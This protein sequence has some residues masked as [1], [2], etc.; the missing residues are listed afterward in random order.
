MATRRTLTTIKI[1]PTTSM[2]EALRPHRWNGAVT[3]ILG[4]AAL[5]SVVISLFS[6]S[7]SYQANQ[8]NARQGDLFEKQVALVDEATTA[9]QELARSAK[10]H[11]N[12]YVE[13]LRLLREEK[14]TRQRSDFRIALSEAEKLCGDCFT[15]PPDYQIR[16]HLEEAA[17]LEEGIG[18]H[19]TPIDYVKLAS[20]GSAVWD[21]S[22]IEQYAQRALKKSKKDPLHEHYAHLMLGHAHFA[23]FRIDKNADERVARVHFDEAVALLTKAPAS[24]SKERLLGEAYALWVAHEA[25]LKNDERVVKLKALAITHWSGSSSRECLEGQLSRDIEAATKGQRPLAPCRLLRRGNP[26][27][28]PPARAKPATSGEAAPKA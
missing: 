2:K 17:R 1:E 20:V 14:T 15:C 10:E 4:L 27:C 26:P 3:I 16:V 7:L 24:E 12:I 11:A 9:S 5:I 18:E 8:S 28:F 21:F 23:H 6:L 19:L 25:F 22:T 13:D